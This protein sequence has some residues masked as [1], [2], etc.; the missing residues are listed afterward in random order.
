MLKG[1]VPGGSINDAEENGI[2]SRG[3]I[4]EIIEK[5]RRVRSIAPVGWLTLVGTGMLH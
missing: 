5:I 4:H 1:M 3:L 2:I